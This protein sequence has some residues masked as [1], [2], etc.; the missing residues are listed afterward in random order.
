MNNDWFGRLPAI[1][2]SPG[3]ST[4]GTLMDRELEVGLGGLG[5]DATLSLGSTLVGVL[6]EQPIVDRIG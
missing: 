6:A 2:N 5:G 3:T 1:G 4:V